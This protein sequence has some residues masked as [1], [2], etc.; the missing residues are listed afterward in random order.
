MERVDR[1]DL[2]A[3]KSKSDPLGRAIPFSLQRSGRSTQEA[4]RLGAKIARC[5]LATQIFAGRAAVPIE[6]IFERPTE[7]LT[8]EGA[9]RSSPLENGV[10][11]RCD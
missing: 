11:R 8:S 3:E 2:R 7:G 6:A 9:P 5:E 1:H 10:G 4:E